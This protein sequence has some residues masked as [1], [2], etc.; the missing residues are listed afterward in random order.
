MDA[1][2]VI[3]AETDPRLHRRNGLAHGDVARL[4]NRFDAAVLHE[5]D[6]SGDR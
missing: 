4:S 5:L 2:P 6:G 3:C 1:G